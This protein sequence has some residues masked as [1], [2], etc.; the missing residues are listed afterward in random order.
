M[1]HLPNGLLPD[2]SVLKPRV[3]A[4]L[5]EV[6]VAT[7]E[8]LCE[9]LQGEFKISMESHA[10]ALNA[11]I[12]DLLREPAMGVALA[13]TAKPLAAQAPVGHL[14]ARKKAKREKA[15]RIEPRRALWAYSLVGKKRRNAIAG[16][17]AKGDAANIVNKTDAF[18]RAE[19][20]EAEKTPPAHDAVPH[21]RA[22]SSAA[23]A[24]SVYSYAVTAGHF[25]PFSIRADGSHPLDPE[26]KF[27][28]KMA[29]YQRAR[30]AA[31]QLI[32]AGCGPLR[33]PACDHMLRVASGETATGPALLRRALSLL[34]PG[35]A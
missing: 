1:T 7:M 3:R 14:A 32:T 25:T 16:A 6:G 19:A 11:V 5:E 4:I 27:Y 30:W 18:Q 35:A 12:C 24:A 17:R 9:R 26:I 34:G 20:G 33:G 21:R 10:D 8:D 23:A 15:P 13:A 2:V 22:P 29:R 31:L 28:S